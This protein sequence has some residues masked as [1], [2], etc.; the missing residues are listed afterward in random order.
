MGQR[1]GLSTLCGQTYQHTRQL[2]GTEAV[3]MQQHRE[4]QNPFGGV[5]TLKADAGPTSVDLSWTLSS[6]FGTVRVYDA[7]GVLLSAN[8]YDSTDN[9][10]TNGFFKADRAYYNVTGLEP[11]TSYTV[12]VSKKYLGFD[13]VGSGTHITFTTLPPLPPPLIV[14]PSFEEPVINSRTS[15]HTESETGWNV[16]DKTVYTQV[17][18]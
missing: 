16:G 12:V 11:G 15:Y 18:P 14:N 5:S 7:S 1:P 3:Q 8:D 6:S 13:W 2:Q 9:D 10:K 4:Q 17:H